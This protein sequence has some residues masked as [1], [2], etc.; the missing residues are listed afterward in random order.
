[1]GSEGQGA[2][3]APGEN[4]IIWGVAI[5][6]LIAIGVLWHSIALFLKPLNQEFGWSATEVASAF[7]LALVVADIF[8]IPFGYLMDRRGGR[9]IM[10]GGGL[11]GAAALMSVPHINSL[12]EL[13]MAFTG[14]GISQSM[15]LGNIPASVV[16]ANVKDFRRGLT[17]AAIIGGLS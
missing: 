7:T 13:Y 5:S 10:T 6:Q 4:R 9:W 16:T 1:M 11:V 12:T 2:K 17:Y 14:V 8:A 15:L 3:T